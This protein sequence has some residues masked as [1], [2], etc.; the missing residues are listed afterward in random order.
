MR[1][2]LIDGKSVAAALRTALKRDVQRL[3]ATHGRVRTNALAT[4]LV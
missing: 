1:A 4:S 2:T 3:S